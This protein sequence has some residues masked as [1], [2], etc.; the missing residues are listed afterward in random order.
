[1][2]NTL[3]IDVREACRPQR[4]GKGQ[5]TYGFVSELLR[6]KFPMTLVTDRDL[7]DGWKNAN[8][9][10]ISGSGIRWHWKVVRWLKNQAN[11][12]YLSPT[13]YLVPAFAP[14]TVRCIPVIHDLIAFHD[15]P[16]DRK[17]TLIE[18]WTLPRVIRRCDCLCTISESTKKDLLARYPDLDPERVTPIFAGP[19]HPHPEKSQPDR[20]TI[21]CVATLCPRK[22]QLRLICSFAQLPEDLRSTHR[23]VLAGGRGWQDA[24]I[25]R[26]ARETPGVEW[27]GYIDGKQYESLL[28]TCTV[29]ALPSLYEG[30][31]M[32]ILDALQRGVPVLT[33][34]RGSLKEL[35]DGAAQIVDPESTESI[36]RG[37]EELLRDAPFRSGLAE[38]GRRRA[39]LYSWRRTVDLFLGVVS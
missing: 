9:M 1:M 19:L 3:V 32:Q 34:D 24:E 12:T 15:E 28:S 33:S 20:K 29:F 37:L 26:A 18:R 27:L 5:W 13:S 16:H 36:S 14:R 35:A 31:G 11:V 39:A 17:A 10:H 30:F 2:T 6:R 21:L 4:T 38:K 7:P 23:L 8:G 22:N 25:V